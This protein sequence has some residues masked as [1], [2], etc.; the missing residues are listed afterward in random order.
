[1]IRAPRSPAPPALRSEATAGVP[2]GFKGRRQQ[3]EVGGR[4]TAVRDQR[5]EGGSQSEFNA[6]PPSRERETPRRNGSTAQ[7][8]LM[9]PLGVQ[10]AKDNDAVVKLVGKTA[11]EQTTK[12]TVVNRTAFR[13]F[14]QH[15]DGLM[16]FRQEFITQTPALG[17]IPQPAF[18]CV[19]FGIGPNDD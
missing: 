11:G 15:T 7:L 16:D 17:F 1:M 14:F 5:T 18:A 9:V 6:T 19:R 3:P 8:S 4:R 13:V 12:P 2:A 10:D